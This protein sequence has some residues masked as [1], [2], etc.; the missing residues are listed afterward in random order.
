M[1]HEEHESHRT[2]PKCVKGC[3]LSRIQGDNEI[4]FMHSQLHPHDESHYCNYVYDMA[5]KLL[6]IYDSEK[7]MIEA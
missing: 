1:I 6:G 4:V 5:G 7:N 3:D 2:S